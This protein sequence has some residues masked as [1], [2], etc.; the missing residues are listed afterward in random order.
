M[1]KQFL[2]DDAGAVTIDWVALTAGVV[3]L[4]VGIIAVL[5]DEVS[6]LTT[7]IQNNLD[8]AT[9]GISAPTDN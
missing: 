1:F 6:E 9:T 8:A 4:G 2:N 5:D 3:L 7:S